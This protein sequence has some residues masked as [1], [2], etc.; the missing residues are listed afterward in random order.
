MRRIAAGAPAAN[1][2]ALFGKLVELGQ[3][4]S[5]GEALEKNAQNADAYVDKLCEEDRK[6]Q[7]SPAMPDD[8][9]MQRDAAEFMAPLMDCEKP[10]DQPPAKALPC[11][12]RLAAWPAWPGAKTPSGRIG[13]PRLSSPLAQA[14]A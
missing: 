9:G 5:L 10:L 14:Y 1:Q 13:W 2:P 4:L 6:L 12:G 11:L 7:E 8:A 3:Q